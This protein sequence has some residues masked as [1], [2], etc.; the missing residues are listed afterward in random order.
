MTIDLQTIVDQATGPVDLEPTDTFVTE[1]PIRIADRSIE[2]HGHG[3]QVRRLIA[4][5][6]Q[7]APM[8]ALRNASGMIDGLTLTGK[9]D[10]AQ[11][12]VPS[13]EG[14]AGYWLMGCT[15][16]KL[17]GEI[18]HVPGD[19]VYLGALSGGTKAKSD[20]WVKP[21]SGIILDLL[22]DDAGRHGLAAV[23]VKNRADGTKG[24]TIL[25]SCHFANWHRL[26][27]DRE[28]MG[29]GIHTQPEDIDDQGATWIK[30]T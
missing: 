26:R 1:T 15:D 6:K 13:V 10:P 2:L 7:S 29:A 17:T 3:A 30:H 25:A 20:S 18:D 28:S 14:H 12:Y 24:L 11:G 21:C 4:I 22:C 27:I 5:P 19:F 16:L 8:F 9:K 23:G